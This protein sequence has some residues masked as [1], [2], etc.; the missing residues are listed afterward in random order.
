MASFDRPKYVNGKRATGTAIAAYKA[1]KADSTENLVLIAGAGDDIVGFTG[2]ATAAN[3]VAEIFGR[4]GD[5][6]A[7]AGGTISD[8]DRLKVD[9]N[10]D[11][12]VAASANDIAVA[13]ARQDAVDNDVFRVEVGDLR[14][15]A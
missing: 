3:A 5:A 13:I 12:I 14:I 2:S 9:A 15:H 11:L 1:V 8:G 4:S 10:G 7:T 6:L